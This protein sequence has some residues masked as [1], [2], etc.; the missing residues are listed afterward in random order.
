M[1]NTQDNPLP[2]AEEE[3][4]ASAPP[5]ST[6]PPLETD[7]D[8]VVKCVGLTKVFRDFWMRSRVRAVDGVDLEIYRG[9][10][11]GLL[12]PNGS[13]KSTT[14]KMILGLLY[15]TSGRIAVFGKRADDVATKKLIGYL[16]EESH[17]YPFL[18]ARETLD[19]YG[20]LF[21]Q[22]RRQRRQRTDMLLEMVGLEAVQRRP[23]G[24]Y[25]KGMQRR[26]GLAQALINDPK[27][28]ILDE[29]TNGLDPI[30]TR[31]IKDLIVELSQRGKAVL[32]CSHLL[33]DVEDVCDRVAIMFGGKIRTA[34]P[35][36][37]LLVKQDVTTLEIADLDDEVMSKLEAVLT[38]YKKRIERVEKPRQKLESLFLDIV[39][40]AQ[41]AGVATSGA[42][43][44][45]DIAEFLV[46]SQTQSESPALVTQET[47]ATDEVIEQLIQPTPTLLENVDTPGK[48]TTDTSPSAKTDHKEEIE[49]QKVPE[50]NE[51]DKEHTEHPP[52]VS[53]ETMVGP[54]DT[55]VLD[56]LLEIDDSLDEVHL[57]SIEFDKE[58][59]EGDIEPT[60]LELPAEAQTPENSGP[61]S[62]GNLN[63]DAAMFSNILVE[64]WLEFENAGPGDG[65]IQIDLGEVTGVDAV[66][67]KLTLPQTPKERD[68]EI[69][70]TKKKKPRASKNQPASAKHPD[71]PQPKPA[72]KKKEAN[73]DEQPDRSFLDAID[74]VPPF[75]P[76]MPIAKP[77]KK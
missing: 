53:E 20:R 77:K 28:L 50:E 13:G 1:I 17:L 74:E 25:S 30:G 3:A 12:G 14:I 7:T 38:A 16:P 72:T 41:D 35:V 55:S 39:A 58:D 56:G 42:K 69:K 60:S 44:G 47:Q 31:Q 65:S 8:I 62:S 23:V 26:I 15:P 71:A 67:E 19:Y 40:A 54:E 59:D 32:L 10:V 49:P 61:V 51:N 22:P 4:A 52:S 70:K 46:D 21:H 6:N 36:N 43:T 24:E 68:S 5:V 73:I 18:N 34:G 37:D 48:P 2:I 57:P 9:E 64:D 76:E 11:F 27:L 66:E 45:G 29:P 33:A 75:D 63:D